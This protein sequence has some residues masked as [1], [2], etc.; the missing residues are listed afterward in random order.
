MKTELV[1]LGKRINVASQGRR[2]YLV[3]LIYAGFVTLMILWFS[4]YATLTTLLVILALGS[5]VTSLGGRNYEGGDERELHRREHAHYV[6]YRY[7]GNVLVLALFAAYFRGPNPFTPALNPALRMFLYH[8]PYVLLM[9]DD[10]L[11]VTLPQAILLWTEPDMEL[12]A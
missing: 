10:I 7:L 9:A 2:R 6:A 1:L 3:V 5:L 11:Y 12:E 4:G 8:L